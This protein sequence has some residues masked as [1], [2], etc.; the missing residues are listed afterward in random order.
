MKKYLDSFKRLYNSPFK[1]AL[2]L[3]FLSITG[4]LAGRDIEAT[5]TLTGA[6]ILM[7][8]IETVN[9]SVA[10]SVMISRKDVKSKI[11]GASYLP[12]FKFKKD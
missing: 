9:A 8:H 7:G 12:S 1:Y 10:T 3:L 11:T 6:F 2:L 4:L 5:I